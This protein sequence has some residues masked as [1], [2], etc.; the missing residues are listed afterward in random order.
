MKRYFVKIAIYVVAG[1]VLI[2]AIFSLFKYR[3]SRTISSIPGRV[4]SS[5]A[6]V[7]FKKAETLEKQDDLLAAKQA[8]QK[9]LYDYPNAENFQKL[10]DKISFLNIK[11]LF[12]PIPTSQSQLYEVASGDSLEKIAKR[13][14]TTIELIKKANNLSGNLIKPGS[15]LKVQNNSFSIVVDKS[16]NTLTLASGEEVIKIYPVSTGKDNST[17][18]GTFKIVNKLI[19]PS[20]YSAK[21]VIPPDS[22]ENVL[23]TRW[24]G[25]DKPGYGIHGTDDP[26]TIGYQCT[27][28]CIRMHNTDAEELYA[29][30][31]SGT[32]VTIID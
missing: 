26:S 28:G 19:N 5:E 23:G 17:P 15:K 22:P 13:F 14:N 8:Y 11:I 4:F 25:I 7:L 24:L 3:S 27:E 6:A 2:I 32:E 18:V 21:G 29:I 16:Q 30:V 31:P 1:A 20:W 12:S 10:Q 9:L